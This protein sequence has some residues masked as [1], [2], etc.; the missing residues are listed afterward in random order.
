MPR[1]LV[2]EDCPVDIVTTL[3]PLGRGSS[4]LTTRF[5]D[6]EVHRSMWTEVGPAA[7]RFVQTGSHITVEAWGPGSDLAL[8]SSGQLLGLEDDRASFR[9]DH[10]LIADLNRRFR[11]MR[12]TA[13]T[14][15]VEALVPTI[16]EQ[17]VT[18]REARRSFAR[19]VHRFGEPAPGPLSLMM[20]PRP[21]I[22]SALPYWEFHAIGIERRR[23][24]TIRR[25]CALADSLQRASTH[26]PEDFRRKLM[27]VR[28][29]GIWSASEVSRLVRGDPDA[30]SIGDYH[31]PHLVSWALAGEARG[32]DGRMLELLEP[33]KG[34]R[35]RV[36]R[37]LELGH[38][39]PPKFGPRRP[40]RSIERI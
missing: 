9:P 1:K 6:G 7:V 12:M 35:A 27:S 23:A 40:L 30:V 5:L 18:G 32:D 10:P 36:V 39:S 33:F 16:I 14:A 26:P 11:G 31:T 4:D 15:V 2:L 8:R 34:H 21:T 13:G 20:L 3:G 17:K 29:I 38:S 24:D 28:G 22:L 19:L 37:L 25:V